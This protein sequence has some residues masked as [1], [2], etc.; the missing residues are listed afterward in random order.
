MYFM[1]IDESGVSETTHPSQYFITTGTIFHENNLNSMKADIQDYKDTNFVG[2]FQNAE[3]HVYDMWKARNSFFG[4][5]IP[6]KT[7]LVDSLYN[8]ISGLSCTIIAVRIDKQEFIQHHSNPAEILDYAYM[9]LVERF[10]NFLVENDEKG[11]IRIDQTTEPIEAFLNDKDSRILKIINKVR[12]KGTRWQRAAIDI[13]EEP[14]FLQSHVRKGLQVADAV[15]YCVNRKTNNHTDF[16]SFWN[17]IYP[18]FRTSQTGQVL[19]YGLITYP[20]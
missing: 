19:G 5:S 13:I 9:L 14:N 15:S 8:T 16:D 20:R 3:I 18:K 12:K 7:A 4:L 1:Y 10:D 6:Q 17:L 2:A 11:I